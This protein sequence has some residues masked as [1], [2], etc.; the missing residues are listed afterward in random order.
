MSIK[1]TQIAIGVRKDSR[2]YVENIKKHLGAIE[3]IFDT[4]LFSGSVFDRETKSTKA[5]LNFNYDLIP[6]IEF[7]ILE[8]TE[9]DNWHVQ[10]GSGTSSEPFISHI[11]VHIDNWSEFQSIKNKLMESGIGIAQEAKTFSH[12][13]ENIPANRKYHYIIMDTVFLFGFDLKLIYRRN[14]DDE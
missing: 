1:L 6:G 10:R 14:T 12:S 5:E 4:V 7:E 9:G 13:N 8:Y 11:G 2:V 3:W